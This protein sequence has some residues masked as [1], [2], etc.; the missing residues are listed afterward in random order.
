MSNN[1]LLINIV[2]IFVLVI[3]INIANSYKMSEGN[4]IDKDLTLSS[5]YDIEYGNLCEINFMLLK[6][7]IICRKSG[8][9]WMSGNNIC[10]SVIGEFIEFITGL[11]V[12]DKFEVNDRI[13]EYGL[14]DADTKIILK[15][16]NGKIIE[17]TVGGMNPGGVAIYIRKSDEKEIILVGSII[18]TE[19][20]HVAER[21]I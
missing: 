20:K 18:L 11:P 12:V 6:Q 17:F 5:A 15:Q 13:K 1:R 8:N 14:E 3:S 19:L 9:Q 16:W 21:I 10:T 4:D 2:L 7:V